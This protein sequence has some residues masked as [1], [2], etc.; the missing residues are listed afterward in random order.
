[1]LESQGLPSG[2]QVPVLCKQS[3][4]SI[5]PRCRSGGVKPGEINKGAGIGAIESKILGVAVAQVET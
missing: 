1:M 2:G 4:N 5:A 3:S